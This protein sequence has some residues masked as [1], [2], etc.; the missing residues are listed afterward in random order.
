MF[1]SNCKPHDAIRLHVSSDGTAIQ[2]LKQRNILF[3]L[4]FSFSSPPLPPPTSPPT[5][6][7][8][9]HQRPFRVRHSDFSLTF[10]QCHGGT[11]SR[12]LSASKMKILA[13]V[14]CSLIY[15]TALTAIN[16]RMNK[17]KQQI[18]STENA[19]R[20]F[21]TGRFTMF[22]VITNI[23]SK[24]TKGP[25]LMEF[26]TVTGKLKFFFFYMLPRVATT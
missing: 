15:L 4:C 24:K 11:F 3:F 7:L 6:I 2:L 21:N 23:C 25:T 13:Q 14:C 8:L 19:T 26:F 10:Q 12:Y 16:N 18:P 22:S 5:A 20:K 1:R 9:A 17:S